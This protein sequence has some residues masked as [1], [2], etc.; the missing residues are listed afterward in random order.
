MFKPHRISELVE[1]RRKKEKGFTKKQLAQITGLTVKT[2]D[3]VSSAKTSTKVENL[4]VIA[5]AFGV[6]MNYFF[7]QFDGKE[8]IIANSSNGDENPW[9]ICYELQTKVA[10]LEKELA[11]CRRANG[12]AGNE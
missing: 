11:E 2:I 5:M 10:E 9:K 8:T 1:T 12:T 7:D 4:E 3:D 6:D